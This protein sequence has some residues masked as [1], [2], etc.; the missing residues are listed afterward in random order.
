MLTQEK[1]ELE[2]ALKAHQANIT[3]LTNQNSRMRTLVA[4][5]NA[6]LVES[7]DTIQQDKIELKESEEKTKE[8]NNKMNQLQR[9][10]DYRTRPPTT[11]LLNQMRLTAKP[12]MKILVPE[13]NQVWCCLSTSMIENSTS[14][15]SSGKNRINRSSWSLSFIISI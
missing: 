7:R 5:A 4:Q 6:Q 2:G 9:E 1:I 8:L 15:E 10:F 14:I 13:G 11:E 12:L 3:K